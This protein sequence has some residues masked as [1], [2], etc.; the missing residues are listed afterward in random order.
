MDEVD[1]LAEHGESDSLFS[2]TATENAEVVPPHE[3]R[4]T[5]SMWTVSANRTFTQN[6]PAATTDTTVS[7][8]SWDEE[9]SS[10]FPPFPPPPFGRPYRSPIGGRPTAGEPDPVTVGDLWVETPLGD[11]AT[12][13]EE[14]SQ[15]A[16]IPVTEPVEDPDARFDPGST[17]PNWT[18]S[19]EQVF[20]ED[21]PSGPGTADEDWVND[22]QPEEQQSGWEP[23]SD[24]YD[25]VGSVFRADPVDRSEDVIEFLDE[26]EEQDPL[27]DPSVGSMFSNGD[28]RVSGEMFDAGGSQRVPNE[29]NFWQQERSHGGFASTT[30]S[31]G[32]VYSDEGSPGF[33]AAV[34]RLS[35]Q[36]RDRATIPLLIA[37][38]VLAPDEDVLG[39]VVG[40]MLG[41]PAVIVLSSRRVLVINDR[42]WQPVV[43]V[44]TLDGNL[45]VRGRHD[46]N[47]AA[48]GVSDGDALSMV[49][50]IFDVQGAMNLVARMR[51]IIDGAR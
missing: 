42:R 25:S 41:R 22:P 27:V 7:G 5:D 2:R 10:S 16:G 20:P 6:E 37:G 9:S 36:E 28:R 21:P 43:D 51:S 1:D 23:R 49:D 47:V 34:G 19:E 30:F 14:S 32:D 17:D 18:W 35:I 29:P 3:H 44:Y 40:Q 38:A 13:R 26:V 50:G 45:E 8:P 39:L 24:P 31:S 33:A 4:T 11:E 46:R 15:W 48:V 12:Q